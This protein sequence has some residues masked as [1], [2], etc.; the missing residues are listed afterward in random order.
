[1]RRSQTSSLVP[2]CGSTIDTPERDVSI[3][4]S[5]LPGDTIRFSL[6]H[7]SRYV[8]LSCCRNGFVGDAWVRGELGLLKLA[9]EA[10]VPEVSVNAELAIERASERSVAECPLVLGA[11]G[12]F[13]L[14]LRAANLKGS[15]R[16]WL[17]SWPVVGRGAILSASLSSRGRS[18]RCLLGGCCLK[19]FS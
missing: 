1:M 15:S 4:S 18:G 9:D 12:C 8:L 5:S 2:E 11:G 19:T 6:L 7:R 16:R 13:W 17:N 14:L 3:S 10:E